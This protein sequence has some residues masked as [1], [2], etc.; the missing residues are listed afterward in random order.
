MIEVLSEYGPGSVLSSP[1]RRCLDTVAP[2]AAALGL[3]VEWSDA[4]AEGSG[5]AAERL[6]RSVAGTDTVLCSHGD[7]IPEILQKLSRTD[8][9]DL[10]KSPRNEKAS[11]W[12]LRSRLGRFTE[13]AYL[14]PPRVD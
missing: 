12:V 5:V 8:G 2:L 13:A 9:V 11:T 10:G 6:V 3:E 14:K 4:L 1:Y 7:V